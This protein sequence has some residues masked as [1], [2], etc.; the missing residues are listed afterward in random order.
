MPHA[1]RDLN[2]AT[3]EAWK[4]TKLSTLHINFNTP[5]KNES[6]SHFHLQSIYFFFKNQQVLLI[7]SYTSHML[8]LLFHIPKV[9]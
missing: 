8:I 6:F 4:L 7:Y 2:C 3:A 9:L 5:N 1:K